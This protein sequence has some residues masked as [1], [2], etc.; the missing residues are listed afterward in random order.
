MEKQENNTKHE[1]RTQKNGALAFFTISILM[2]TAY[3]SIVCESSFA[4]LET[5]PFVGAPF[6][7]IDRRGAKNATLI[8]RD[9]QYWRLLTSI[10][11]THG[12]IDLLFSVAIL[13]TLGRFLERRWGT[14]RWL[15]IYI[16]SGTTKI[17]ISS[18]TATPISNFHHNFS[19][20]IRRCS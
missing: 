4:P 11:L 10:F 5:N 18:C 6:E 9:K 14:K 7:A 3:L 1:E 19:F 16:G 17:L 2:I 12:L 13:C 15:L 20:G 8:L